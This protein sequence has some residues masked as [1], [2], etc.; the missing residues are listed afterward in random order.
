VD[1]G[2]RNSKLVR[3][4]QKHGLSGA[5][6]LGAIPG[7][8]GG[9]IRHNA[10]FRDP[11]SYRHHGKDFRQVKNLFISDLVEKI[12]LLSSQGEIITK[13]KKYCQFSHQPLKPRSIFK[14]KQNVIVSA[15][16]KLK[17][18]DPRLIAQ[19]IKKV[20]AWRLTRASENK[21]TQIDP[22]TKSLSP[23]PSGK[24]AGCIFSNLPNPE[25]HP[26]GRMIDL[27]GLKGT[28]V[29]GAKVSEL[30]ANYI[31]NDKNATAKNITDLIKIIKKAVKKKFAVELK[32]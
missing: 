27:C 1:S 28:R 30:H 32:E 26:T 16:L 21:K 2:I 23:Q 6:F 9:A 31:I 13:G 4:C 18:E 25:G 24:S 19:T 17:K 7:T 12:T 11:R 5:E 20:F 29:G 8:I 22:F 10:R 3:F 14:Q 15:V